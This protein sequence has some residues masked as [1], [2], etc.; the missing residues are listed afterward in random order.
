VTPENDYCNYWSSHTHN[1]IEVYA[2]PVPCSVDFTGDLVHPYPEQPC[3]SSKFCPLN[4]IDVLFF[5]PSM[6]NPTASCAF[7]LLT[8]TT[9]ILTLE[10]SSLLYLSESS[11]KVLT[12]PDYHNV[13]TLCI[14]DS[15][16]VFASNEGMLISFDPDESQISPVSK[17]YNITNDDLLQM[18]PL[19]RR[20]R[21]LK[22]VKDYYL[23]PVSQQN[24]GFTLKVLWNRR[25]ALCV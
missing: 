22:E 3:K 13:K 20:P 2:K 5:P 4:E 8:I 17:L 24:L 12:F 6:L 21:E 23:T 25:P 7:I 18:R 11:S 9:G 15:N 19:E 1:D 10:G 14:R 16:L